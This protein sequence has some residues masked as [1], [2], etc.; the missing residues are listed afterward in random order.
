MFFLSYFSS[1]VY[2]KSSYQFMQLFHSLMHCLLSESFLFPSNLSDDSLGIQ[3][4]LR[5]N[6][7][8]P[9]ESES[10]HCEVALPQL[11][12]C[13]WASAHVCCFSQHKLRCGCCL[14]RHGCVWTHQRQLIKMAE[15]IRFAVASAAPEAFSRVV[16]FSSVKSETLCS[17]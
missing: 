12:L 5:L 9:V 17:A 8:W 14:S 10:G 16:P 1:C 13:S 4:R 6:V 3:C 2:L 15:G 7:L 11:V